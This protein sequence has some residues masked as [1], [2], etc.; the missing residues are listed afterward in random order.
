MFIILLYF[1]HT[2]LDVP[3]LRGSAV[4][5]LFDFDNDEMKAGIWNLFL[6]TLSYHQAISCETSDFCHSPVDFRVHSHSYPCSLTHTPART[7]ARI[8]MGKWQK[9]T[10]QTPSFDIRDFISRRKWNVGVKYIRMICWRRAECLLL[11]CDEEE[12]SLLL[13]LWSFILWCLHQTR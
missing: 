10:I 6:N 1:W 2:C 9:P 11:L 3:S 4:W 12:W 5:R 8:S 13:C 7:D